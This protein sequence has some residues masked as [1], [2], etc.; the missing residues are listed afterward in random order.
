MLTVSVWLRRKPASTALVIGLAFSSAA[1]PSVCTEIRVI[2]PVVSWPTRLP[3]FSAS[4]MYGFSFGASSAD[5]LGMLSALVTP[6][7]TRKSAICSATWMAT[8]TCA[9]VVDAP[10]CGV[11]TKLGVP[12][13]GDALAGSSTN[14]SKAAPP[15]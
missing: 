9:S 2:A 14:T 12:N 15:M 1:A 6:P 4:A 3:S 13:S 7:D 11:D 8:L 5:R 10:R